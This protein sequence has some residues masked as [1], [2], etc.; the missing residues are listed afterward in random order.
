MLATY[1]QSHR[2]YIII[3]KG[4]KW[5]TGRKYWAK[6]EQKPA[7]HTP[8]SA[9]PCLI[10]KHSSDLQLF[11]VLLVAAP[12]SVCLWLTPGLQLSHSS[13]INILVSPMESRLHLHSFTQWP[14][15]FLCRSWKFSWVWFCPHFLYS[16]WR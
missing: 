9:S 5:N 14:P 13:D 2:I 12:L 4:R 7:G 6:R 11:S 8:V 10:S 16:F 1:N 3:P 15:W